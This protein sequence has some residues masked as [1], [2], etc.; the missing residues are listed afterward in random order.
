[1]IEAMYGV[2]LSMEFCASLVNDPMTVRTVRQFAV[3]TMRKLGLVAADK[4]SDRDGAEVAVLVTSELVTNAC[5]HTLG[6]V[7]LR[8]IWDDNVLTIEV[9]DKDSN[10]CLPAIVPTPERGGHGGFGLGLVDQLSDT[11]G[12]FCH[13]S[14]KT[15][16]ARVHLTPGDAPLARLGDL[17]RAMAPTLFLP[18][19]GKA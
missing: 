19:K 4:Q 12:T 5:R 14:G 9:D 13:R 8:Q 3:E 1:M 15:V 2:R 11:W 10:T 17:W 7:S 6:V 18:R 16:F